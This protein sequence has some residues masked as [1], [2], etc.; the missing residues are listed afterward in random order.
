MDESPFGKKSRGG[1]PRCCRLPRWGA[2][3]DSCLGFRLDS[4]CG[5]RIP[6]RG[7]NRYNEK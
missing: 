7:Q 4:R 6:R 3:L 5:S 1:L 2:R